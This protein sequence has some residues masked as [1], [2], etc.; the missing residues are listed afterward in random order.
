M[1]TTRTDPW[2]LALMG[3]SSAAVRARAAFDAAA[4]SAAPTLIVADR[5]LEA[6]AIARSLHARSR[7]GTPLVIINCAAADEDVDRQLFGRPARGASRAELETLGA[8]SAVMRA[9]GGTLYLQQIL[10]LPATTQRRLARVLR[11]R[12][13]SAAGRRSAV[14]ARVLADAPAS[15][16]S[17]VRDGQLRSD[18][19]RRL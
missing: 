1:Y 8:D 7:A 18:L 9:K 17:D 2:P 10:E 15:V 12:E 4:A 13:V 11:D 6:E 5:G 16:A 19:F 14:R 3:P